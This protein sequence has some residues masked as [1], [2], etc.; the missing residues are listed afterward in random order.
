MRDRRVSAFFD[1]LE[2]WLIICTGA[3]LITKNT[4]I[5][6]IF[7]GNI[8]SV[9]TLIEAV[10]MLILCLTLSR[11]ALYHKLPA[12][13]MALLLFLLWYCIR[14]IP[15]GVLF[16]EIQGKEI[17][18]FKLIV[19]FNIGVLLTPGNR[20]KMLNVSTWVLCSVFF[21]IGI[22]GIYLVCS[23]GNVL[24]IWNSKIIIQN[25]YQN[26]GVL[27]FVEF[28][29]FHRNR[30]SAL[31]M[32][33]LW[34]AL[35]GFC[36]YRRFPVRALFIVMACVFYISV[37]IQHSRSTYVSTSIGLGALAGICLLDRWKSKSVWL[38]CV[39]IPV[40]VAAVVFCAYFGFSLC[41]T[42]INALSASPNQNTYEASV[43]S[44]NGEDISTQAEP[45]GEGN[46][47]T[48][49]V[50]YL[51]EDDT[52]DP[53]STE[54]RDK[55]DFIN[56]LR[57]FTMRTQIW[58]W[59][60][61]TIRKDPIILLLGLPEKDIVPTIRNTVETNRTFSHL[62]NA[63]LQMLMLAGIPGVLLFITFLVLWGVRVV[64]KFFSESSS[65][66]KVLVVLCGTVLVSALIEPLF[67]SYANYASVL[68]MF[69][70]GITYAESKGDG[71][72]ISSCLRL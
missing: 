25:E 46:G 70:A 36:S 38:K 2:P 1:K 37:A 69:A 53:S 35:Y 43:E 13:S 20:K 52:S 7:P 65:G 12:A 51:A 29:G 8:H 56:D 47:S 33:A 11:A 6:V 60:F 68:F 19:F 72:D 49:A 55:R 64:K 15:N 41:N 59:A 48:E 34:F 67:S 3:M 21:L 44:V 42:A 4:M 39:C 66:F 45:A 32:I 16:R 24:R 28:L 27:R 54:L 63:F 5:S 71:T 57:T 10:L 58:D 31:F 14:R 22:L 9:L 62:H 50:P 26:T 17:F 18:Y 40:C 30:S 23:G 61:Q